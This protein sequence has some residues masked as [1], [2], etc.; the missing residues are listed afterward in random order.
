MRLNTRDKINIYTTPTTSVI[1]NRIS[2]CFCPMM[3]FY[4]DTQF[5]WTKLKLPLGLRNPSPL[6]ISTYPQRLSVTG[7]GKEGTKSKPAFGEYS[8]VKTDKKTFPVTFPNNRRGFDPTFAGWNKRTHRTVCVCCI[9]PP[10][11]HKFGLAPC[12]RTG[13]LSVISSNP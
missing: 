10:T 5:M 9:S 8:F 7:V 13:S 4:Y 11:V 1:G 2:I 3:T 12:A 6:K